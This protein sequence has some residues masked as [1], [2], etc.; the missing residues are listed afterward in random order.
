MTFFSSDKQ[1]DMKTFW[2]PL[3]KNYEYTQKHFL[4]INLMYFSLAYLIY[5]ETYMGLDGLLL[6]GYG[7]YYR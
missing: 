6:L 1:M 2:T 7:D 4:R 5:N 3:R